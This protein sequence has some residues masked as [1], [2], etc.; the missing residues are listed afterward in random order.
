MGK[1]TY[2]LERPMITFP[3][4]LFPEVV[5]CGAERKAKAPDGAFVSVTVIASLRGNEGFLSLARSRKGNEVSY[6]LHAASRSGR[7]TMPVSEP[8][9]VGLEAFE[10]ILSDEET[11]DRILGI[12]PAAQADV[13]GRTGFPPSRQAV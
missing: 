4:F 13:L 12:F 3:L 11:R 7:V 10:A 5:P 9:K 6:L 2:L 1:L 8:S